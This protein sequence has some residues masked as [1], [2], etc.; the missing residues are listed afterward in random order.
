MCGQYRKL[1]GL[2]MRV[3]HA[4]GYYEPRDAVSHDWV[5]FLEKLGYNFI[6]I[7]NALREREEYLAAFN[8]DG[9]ILT[10][11]DSICPQSYGEEH[12]MD[13]TMFPA[14]DNT[15]RSVID[16]AVKMK[17]PVLGVCRGM[18]YINAY[19]GGRL[20]VDIKEQKGSKVE[21]VASTHDITV[22]DRKFIDVPDL[23]VNSYHN[24]GIDE[25]V[26]GKD[27]VPWAISEDGIIEAVYH[28]K[29]PIIGMMWHPERENP[30][31]LADEEIIKDLF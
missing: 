15:E 4:Q 9:F 21:H 6:Y 25:S 12:E 22:I 29:H 24:Q 7:P 31:S 14:R 8:F 11:G 19:F 5:F 27:L 28:K 13:S 3:V 17:K 2:T 1:L 16:Y 10:G 18:Q 23:T 20:I 26:L 30:A